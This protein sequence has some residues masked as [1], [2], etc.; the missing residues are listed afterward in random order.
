MSK[1]CITGG[2][3][4]IGSHLVTFLHA[5]GM[6]IGVLGR[7]PAPERA[8]PAGVHY[9]QGDLDHQGQLEEALK[10]TTEIVHLAYS[11][12]P[13]TSYEDPVRDILANLPPAVRLLEAASRVGVRKVV[14][15]SS[16]GTVYGRAREIPISEE[17]PTNPISPYGITKLALE[18]YGLMFHY[19]ADLPVVIVRPGNAYG[20]GQRPFTGQ[21]F[22]ATAMGSILCHREI[23]LFGEQGTIRDYLHVDDVVHGIAAA[24]EHGVP[25]SAYNIG[26]GVGHTNHE[27]LEVINPLARAAGYQPRIRIVPPRPFDVPISVLD[28][29]KL[30]RDANWQPKIP[31]E[32]GLQRT[33]N[34]FQAQRWPAPKTGPR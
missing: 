6:E 12:V 16:G 3:G 7:K 8:L 34:W 17:H 14:L 15:A 23:V 18:K 19:L 32:E 30:R 1:C 29:Q 4:F 13:R 25:G 20:E 5:Q 33:W 26:S 22:V 9:V 27:I 11:T 28:C 31:L 10:G 2:A 24:L 21:G